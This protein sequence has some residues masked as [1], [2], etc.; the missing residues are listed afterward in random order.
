M[1]ITF[2]CENCKKKIKAPDET[3]GKW[4]SCPSCKHKC[5]IPLPESEGQEELTLA[6]LDESEVS[7]QN[8][9][10]DETYS[11]TRQILHEKAEPEDEQADPPSAVNQGELSKDITMYLRAMADGDLENAHKL[12]AEVRKSGREAL[13][14]LDA[15]ADSPGPELADV[16][17]G[18]LSGLIRNFRN[19]LR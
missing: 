17:P 16:A 14:V 12:A 8:E 3:G 6:P 4:G 15:I 11:L 1:T 19:Q 9:M 10:M 18:L 7:R 2:H 5:Y 13:D